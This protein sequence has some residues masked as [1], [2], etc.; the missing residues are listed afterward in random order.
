MSEFN[1]INCNRLSWQLIIALT[2]GIFAVFALSF[3]NYFI[4]YGLLTFAYGVVAHVFND[5]SDKKY[6]QT[7]IQIILIIV[8]LGAIALIY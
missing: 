4:N 7:I 6:I 1:I 2:G 5:L 3:D 8:W